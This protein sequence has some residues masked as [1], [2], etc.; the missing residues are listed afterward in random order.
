MSLYEQYREQTRQ[1]LYDQAIAE[2]KE[3]GY[4]NATISAITEKVG[5]AKGTFYNFFK[6]K[7]EVLFKWAAGVFAGLP[8]AQAMD[9]GNT[10]RD[11]LFRLVAIISSAVEESQAL[12]L[13]FLS[14]LLNEPPDESIQGSMDFVALYRRLFEVSS[15]AEAYRKDLDVKLQLVNGA[16]YIGI[17]SWASG[18]TA[19]GLEEYLNKMAS[20]LIS[21][22]RD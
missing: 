8:I 4:E 3:R 2:F 12:F 16:L 9:P 13:A 15:D 14:E 19:L 6:S 21:G 5:V 1:A 17:I 20:M 22:I 10:F 18:K 7:R 11:N